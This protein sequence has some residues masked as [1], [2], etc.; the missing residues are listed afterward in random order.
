MIPGLRASSGFAALVLCVLVGIPFGTLRA[1]PT[2][3]NALDTSDVTWTTGGNATWFGQTAVT[4][5]GTDAAKSGAIVDSQESWIQTAVSGVTNVSFWWKVSSE[6]GYDGLEFGVDDITPYFIS[7]NVDW[8]QRTFDLDAGTHILTWRYFKDEADFGNLDTAWLDQVTF[9]T[10]PPTAPAILTQPT[11]QTV[12]VG[13]DAT[14]AVSV[15]A[16]PFPFYQWRFNDVPIAGATTST[17]TLANVATS[18]AGAY[19]VVITNSM[20]AITST[21][22]SLSVITLSDALDATN[23]L[24]TLSGTRPWHGEVNLSHDGFDAGESGLINHSQESWMQTSVTGPG[25]FSFWW[26]VSSETNFDRIEFSLDGAVQKSISGEIDWESYSLNVPAGS[27][28]LR[29]RYAKDSSDVFA[30][31]QDRAWVDQV[32]FL[33]PP[34][35]FHLGPPVALPDGSREINLFGEVDRFYTIQAST[36]LAEWIELTNFFSPSSVFPI[37]DIQATNKAIQFYRALTPSP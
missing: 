3:G 32:K 24:F 29:W 4:H 30:T 23:F 25:A 21:P 6:E 33:T 28:Q 34:G 20:G 9:R 26:K 2:L 14:F 16:F 1:Q 18:N 10:I 12:G 13:A 17:Y 27:H 36:N 22:A 31:G 7:G 8:E 5:D 19:T 35:P 37:V 15:A 11:H